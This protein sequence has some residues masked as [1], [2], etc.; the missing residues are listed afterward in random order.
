MVEVVVGEEE[1][2]DVCGPE[3][4]LDEL[5][6]CCW[7]AVNHELLVA[8]LQGERRAEAGGRGRGRACAEDV[9]G[10]GFGGHCVSFVVP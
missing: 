4:C 6:S 2:V 10:G 8:D 3:T 5:V 9:D 7:A 1:V